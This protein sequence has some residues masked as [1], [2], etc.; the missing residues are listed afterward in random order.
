MTDYINR[1]MLLKALMNAISR[2]PVSFYNG[3]ARSMDIIREFPAADVQPV[4]H[5]HWEDANDVGDCCYRCSKCGYTRD[6]YICS[7]SN[8]C[9]N[10][11][12]SMCESVGKEC[13][14]DSKALNVLRGEDDGNNTDRCE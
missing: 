1:K 12:A 4:V 13:S 8:Y 11:G 7:V 5:G 14:N 9:P 6:S 2:F 3:I 10:C